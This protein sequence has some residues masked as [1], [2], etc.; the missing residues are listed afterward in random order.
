MLDHIG[1][2]VRD[3]DRARAF[4]NGALAPLGIGI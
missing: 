4:Y 1:I 3:V 2:A